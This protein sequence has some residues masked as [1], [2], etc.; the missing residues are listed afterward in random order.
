MANSEGPNSSDLDE[1]SDM[2]LHCLRPELLK[3]GS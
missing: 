2:G 1:K 3:K